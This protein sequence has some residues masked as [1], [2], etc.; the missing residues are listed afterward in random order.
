MSSAIALETF[1]PQVFSTCCEVS[2]TASLED[3]VSASPVASCT[4]GMVELS[5]KEMFHITMHKPQLTQV[6]VSVSDSMYCKKCNVYIVR[7]V[8]SVMC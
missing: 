7:N 2:E 5:A 8:S 3:S 6:I 4:E 1:V